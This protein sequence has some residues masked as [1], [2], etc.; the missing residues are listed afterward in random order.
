MVTNIPS[1]TD[2]ERS[3]IALLNLAWDSV[4]SLYLNLD[5]AELDEENGEE[6]RNNYWEAAQISLS[7]SLALVQ[8]G[9][10]FLLKGRIAAINPFLL[11][12]G[13]PRDWPRY[14]DR[15]DLP[16]ADFRSIDAQ[17][18]IRAHDTVAQT[19]LSDSF[20]S[21]FEQLRRLRNI[22]MHMVDRRTQVDA[23]EVIKEVLE[24]YAYLVEPSAWVTVRR[25]HLETEP[26]SQI[27]VMA[28]HV[29]YL[30]AREIMKAVELL[31]PAL[32]I[33]HFGLNKRQRR[34]YCAYC[35]FACSDFSLK[36]NLA[37][38]NP[39]TPSSSNLHCILCGGDYSVERH[40]CRRV[41]CKGN[42]IDKEEDICLT[43]SEPQE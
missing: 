19:R 32:T 12:S 17:D 36:P 14:C 2:F 26:R 34:Y 10:E 41:G 29:D 28:E 33:K 37:Q 1:Q 18:L 9:T 25:K 3:G 5:V 11:L 24:I 42:V 4:L 6:A 21:R 22:T 15:M 13:D 35:L 8:Q 27:F 40:K 39:N 38:L 30:L 16:F 20:K 23:K 43:C 7:T 31:E